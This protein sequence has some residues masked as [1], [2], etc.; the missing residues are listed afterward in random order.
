MSSAGMQ[1]LYTLETSLVFSLVTVGLYLSFRVLRFPDL[2]AE[3]GFG[4]AALL[5]SLVAVKFSSPWLG[6]LTGVIVGMLAGT[7]T[8]FLANTVR[9]PT[10]LASIL[11][12]TM[13]FSVGILVAGQ[14]HQS[15]ADIW[16]FSSVDDLL[17]NP[18]QTGLLGGFL[19]LLLTSVLLVLL[20]RSGRGL[21]LRVRGENPTLGKELGHSL[22]KWDI[23]GLAVA[24]GVV[25]LG[26]VLLSQ[27]AG[28][29]NISLG[30]GVAISA[31]AAIM[32]AEAVFPNRK[33]EWAFAACIAATFVIQLVRLFALNLGVPDGGLDLVTSLLVICFVW[34][35][36]VRKK[37]GRS[38]LEQIRM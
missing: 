13:C 10:I 5:G 2:T 22:L 25:G 35:S 12:M 9:L 28:Y 21:L 18:L 33:I 7:V 31:L 19:S 1:L 4:L 23:I 29:A 32:L 34:I 27:R 17:Q 15:L 11:T 38:L 30:R 24:N 8:A 37:S 26:A 16:V 6:L 3:G 36:N 14:P 20:L